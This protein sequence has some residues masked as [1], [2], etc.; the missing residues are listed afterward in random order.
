MRLENKV[1]IVTGGGRGI[2]R[3]ISKHFAAEGAR[4]VVAQRD[5]ASG[6]AT[7]Q[8]IR[9][10]GGEAL[11]VQTDVGR[12]EDV[13]Q[14]VAETVRQ[15]GT[16]DILVNNA[17]VLGENGHFL[18]VSPD[19]WARVIQVG[20]TGAFNCG[21]V[22]ARVMA[23]GR[24]GAIINIS[25]TSGMIPQPRC[26]AYGATKG[27]MEVLT[28]SMAVDLA[29]YNIRVN[30]IAPGPI[31]SHAPDDAPPRE[32]RMTLLGR[33]GLAREV[34]TVAVFLASEESS[35][36]TGERIAVDGGALINAYQIYAQERPRRPE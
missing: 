9:E 29:P 24:G 26:C 23:K 20:L 35:F 13:E 8:E 15:F 17:A 6:E 2:G 5:Q 16:V 4:V 1:A 11:F 10:A 25:S 34:A 3:A 21:Q 14:M 7:C 31:Q 32:A 27:G 22:A 36:V 12:R 28:K 19:A 30:T 18:D 33:A